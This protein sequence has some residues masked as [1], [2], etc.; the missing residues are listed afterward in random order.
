MALGA[1]STLRSLLSSAVWE[2]STFSLKLQ[3]PTLK[4]KME[5]RKQ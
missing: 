5:I 1:A 4:K 2:K 3:F